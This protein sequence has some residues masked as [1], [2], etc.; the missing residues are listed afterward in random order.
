MTSDS[1]QCRQEHEFENR[2]RVQIHLYFNIISK[3][4]VKYAPKYIVT[5][6]TLGVEKYFKIYLKI[7]ESISDSN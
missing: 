1:R 5:Y 2:V 7:N 3:G 4:V 6:T